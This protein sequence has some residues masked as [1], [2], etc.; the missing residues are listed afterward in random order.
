MPNA[1]YFRKTCRV[2]A[3]HTAGISNLTPHVVMS[4]QQISPTWWKVDGI[5]LTRLT[6]GQ[7]EFDDSFLADLYAMIGT[8]RGLVEAMANTQV[9][10]NQI[11]WQ[12]WATPRF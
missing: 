7:H 4:F 6:P 8:V 5:G 3:L 2:L 12:Q 1:I 11:N 10:I 9:V